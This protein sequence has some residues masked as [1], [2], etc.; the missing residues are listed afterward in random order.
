MPE[1]SIGRLIT[2]TQ[3]GERYFLTGSFS[4]EEEALAKKG[5][6]FWLIEITLP[7]QEKI[8]RK[9]VALFRRYYQQKEDGLWGLEAVLKKINKRLGKEVQRQNISWVNHLNAIL[10]LFQ[11]NTLHLAPTGEVVAYLFRGNKISN[12]LEVQETPPPLQTFITVVS[13][14]LK[15]GDKIFLASSEF[16]SYMTV[17]TLADYLSLPTEKALAELA[18]YFRER[19]TY[20]VNAL[21]LECG[22][23]PLRVDTVYL[24]QSAPSIWQSLKNSLLRAKEQW[25]K[26]I[27]QVAYQIGKKEVEW[28]QRWQRS[29]Q[30]EGLGGAPS[31]GLLPALRLE[32]KKRFR[33]LEL[34]PHHRRW[35]RANRR[36]LLLL[37]A[38]IVFICFVGAVFSQ[39]GSRHRQALSDK[40]RQAQALF[41]E[42]KTKKATAQE[43]EAYRLLKEAQSLIAQVKNYPPLSSQASE[44]EKVIENELHIL[45]HTRII[46]PLTAPLADF[47]T[48][49]EVETERIFF[50]DGKLVSYNRR[51]NQF[52]FVDS[53]GKVETFFYLPQAVGQPDKAVFVNTAGG[54][55]FIRTSSGDYY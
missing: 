53:S 48:Q 6:I 42:A 37:G 5:T 10:G 38:L 34:K 36:W 26:V 15:E 30:K 52:F 8:A 9:I 35:I 23:A 17:E 24:D 45:T 49:G 31:R 12:I 28:F 55:F 27:N 21:I 54:L 2:S 3:L 14:E 33:F 11:D 50:V 7:G 16:P 19:Q 1:L 39:K 22:G 44:L 20:L 29:R 47:S 41:Q 18:Q 32:T 25:V 40:F 43:Q 51:H 46:S 4:P 13:G